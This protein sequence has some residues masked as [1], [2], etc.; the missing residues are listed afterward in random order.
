MRPL[1][2]LLVGT[3]A[4]TY[5]VRVA[6]RAGGAPATVAVRRLTLARV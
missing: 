3:L 5:G 4:S 6:A 1:A 2:T